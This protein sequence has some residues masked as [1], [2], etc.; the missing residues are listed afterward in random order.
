M[1]PLY[2]LAVLLLIPIGCST[3][4]RTVQPDASQEDSIGEAVF[5]YQFKHNASAF[6]TKLRFSF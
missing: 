5:R 1:R 4:K 3:G 2:L 6:R